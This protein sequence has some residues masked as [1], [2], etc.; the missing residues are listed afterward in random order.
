[1]YVTHRL[2][3]IKHT[4]IWHICFIAFLFG[5]IT[6]ILMHLMFNFYL[7]TLAIPLVITITRNGCCYSIRSRTAFSRKIKP[8]SQ[9]YQES[10]GKCYNTMFQGQKRSI[11]VLF[12]YYPYDS[13]F[14]YL[15]RTWITS[16]NSLHN[17]TWWTLRS[18]VFTLHKESVLIFLSVNGPDGLNFRENVLKSV[19]KTYLHFVLRFVLWCPEV[20]KFLY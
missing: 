6:F 15:I 18:S 3:P 1:M 20:S 11:Y 12:W 19:N 16:S 10:G 4:W 2:S 7:W 8:S 13:I 14:L 5:M 9:T 17:V